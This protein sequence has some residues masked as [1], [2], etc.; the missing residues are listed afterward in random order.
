MDDIKADSF[1]KTLPYFKRIPLPLVFVGIQI[2]GMPN[3]L[4]PQIT[5]SGYVVKLNPAFQLGMAQ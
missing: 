5:R 4:G 1:V 2:C 3:L